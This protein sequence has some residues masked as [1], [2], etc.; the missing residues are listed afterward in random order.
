M[1]MN[2]KSKKFIIYVDLESK[3]FLREY[4]AANDL[5]TYAQAVRAILPL[6]HKVKE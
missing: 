2:K 3:K 1:K 6:K 5:D 4:K